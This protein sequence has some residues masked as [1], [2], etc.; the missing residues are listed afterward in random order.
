MKLHKTWF[1]VDDETN[2]TTEC[3]IFYGVTFIFTFSLLYVTQENIRLICFNI[4]QNG[5]SS[6]M[7][8]ATMHFQPTANIFFRE[9]FSP[10][11][12]PSY[13]ATLD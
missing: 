11:V 2:L 10:L 6:R 4:P 5:N 1:V 13:T 3:F 12:P 8:R 9:Y 7:Q